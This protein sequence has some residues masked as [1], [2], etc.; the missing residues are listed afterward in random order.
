MKWASW[1]AQM[2]SGELKMSDSSSN[3]PQASNLTG[4]YDQVC[5]HEANPA[6]MRGFLHNDNSQLL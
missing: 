2:Q 6:E 4:K 3:S 1:T 5:G